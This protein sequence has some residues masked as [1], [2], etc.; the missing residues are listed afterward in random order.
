MIPH[1][2][3][4]GN[5]ACSGCVPCS[6]CLQEVRARVLSPP[7]MRLLDVLSD[8]SMSGNAE[9]MI[10]AFFQAYTQA[11]PL[12]HRAM[13]ESPDLRGRYVV[14]DRTTS[15]TE[16]TEE[17]ARFVLL[18]TLFFQPEK[19]PPDLL[20]AEDV[21]GAK[22]DSRALAQLLG[23]AEPSPHLEVL[24][25]ERRRLWR[26]LGFPIPVP[27]L[28]EALAP[29][30]SLEADI[31]TADTHPPEAAA[32]VESPP[33]VMAVQETALVPIPITAEDILSTIEEIPS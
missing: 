27:V 24:F 12:F 23:M 2:C 14:S 15:S 6:L 22:H 9:M 30:A 11:W 31:A 7:L 29:T 4:S 25:V 8:P 17:H 10:A 21:E 18:Q 16:P 13:Q 33:V 19:F 28:T 5:P 20:V 3:F 1:V 32:T 26:L